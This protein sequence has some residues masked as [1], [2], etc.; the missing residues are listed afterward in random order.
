MNDRR[1]DLD[2]DETVGYPEDEPTPA[3][4]RAVPL[5]EW[6]AGDDPG[7]I[8]PREWLL[9]NQFCREFISSL[10]AAGGVGKSALRLLQLIS[11]ASGR[12][13]CG[14]HVFKRCRVLLISLEDDRHEL[15]RRI[16]AVLIHFGVPR[17]ELKGWLFC[18]T[19]IG[20]K[21][22]EAQGKKRV[23]GPL[24]R[25]IRDAVARLKPDLVAL[26]PFIKLHSLNENDSGDMNFVCDLLVLL[27]VEAKIAVDVPHHVHKGLIAPGDADAGRGSSGIRD[28]GRLTYTLTPMSEA[29]A[30]MFGVGTEDR[31]AYVRLDSAKVN[32]APH[33]GKAV[34]FHLI[35]VPINNGT[36]QYPSGDTIQVAVPWEPQG[37]WA[38]LDN[39][40]LNSIL[41]KIDAGL[42]DGERYT[43]A[44]SAKDRHAWRVVQSLAPHKSEKQCREII[45][46]WVKN[47]VLVEEDYHSQKER[48]DVKGVRVVNAN[49]PGAEIE[50]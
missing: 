43:A 41:D 3:T 49:R 27:A 47:G 33:G 39:G 32:I 37:L 44:P 8:P 40:T 24:D 10:V 23:A 7:A 29:E 50:W 31:F 19:P 1:F 13:L 22:A 5:N 17:S 2:F 14:Q 48:K 35:G 12:P 45:R 28:A 30:K 20:S 6:D 9:G 38:D 36:P 15:Q 11:L 18:A 34:W 42:P 25:Q 16:T 46:E 21:L 26:D 4:A